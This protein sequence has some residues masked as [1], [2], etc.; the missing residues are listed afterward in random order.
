MSVFARIRRWFAGPI[1]DR[2]AQ[3]EVDSAKERKDLA[4]LSQDTP[5][6]FSGT[7]TPD[8]TPKPE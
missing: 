6:V 1:V 5:T 8:R 4:A 7:V 2:A 3:R